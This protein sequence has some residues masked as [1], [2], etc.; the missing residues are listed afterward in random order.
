MGTRAVAGR[1][2]STRSGVARGDVPFAEVRGASHWWQALSTRRLAPRKPPL[3][4]CV[5][6]RGVRGA[7]APRRLPPR[8]SPRRLS[9]L[10]RRP[11]PRRRPLR[12]PPP[13]QPRPPAP[14]HQGRE[15]ANQR[16]QQHRG[17]RARAPRRLPPRASPRRLSSL[18]RRPPPRRRVLQR[19]PP[20]RAQSPAPRHQGR[21]PAGL[22]QRVGG[23]SRTASAVQDESGLLSRAVAGDDPVARAEATRGLVAE[24]LEVLV[25]GRDG[26]GGE[27]ARDRALQT[28]RA[29]A[30][31]SAR[32]R[33]RA[34]A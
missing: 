31:A 33:A 10:P 15:P 25:V 32:A 1:F 28:R 30:R 26:P 19:P 2:H 17:L 27:E 9:S 29:R 24:A 18:P 6:W 5:A 14:R 7:R 3:C 12:H 13:R 22:R 23:P 34:R 11:P 16:E 20:R 21:K 4:V 8:A